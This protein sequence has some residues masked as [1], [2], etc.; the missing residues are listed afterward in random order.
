MIWAANRYKHCTL[1]TVET[2]AYTRMA[3]S[4]Q[5]NKKTATTSRDIHTGEFFRRK[6]TKNHQKWSFGGLKSILTMASKSSKKT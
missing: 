3:M 5:I 6:K 4:L 1:P 2:K